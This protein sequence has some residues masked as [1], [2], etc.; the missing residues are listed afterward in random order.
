MTGP[1]PRAGGG[2]DWR[3]DG[4]CVAKAVLDPDELHTLRREADRLWAQPVLF[5]QR[6]AVPISP[7][8]NDRLDPV[9][10]LSPPFRALA[11]DPRLLALA[12]A[13][14]GGEPQ[15]FKDKFI[16][17]PPGADGYLAHQDGAYWQQV[18]PS[19]DAFVTIVCFLDDSTAEAGAIECAPGQHSTL[20]TTPGQ[21]A[22]VDESVLT[23]P[24][25]AIELKA[26]DLLLIHSLTP[27]RSG[28]NR[29]GAMRRAL[30]FTYVV[31]PRP[32]LYDRYRD[33]VRSRQS[34]PSEN[35]ED[36][37]AAP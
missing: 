28:P 13:M 31:D 29:S 6:G 2:P 33:W 16:A 5:E 30:L 24:F 35:R 14:L 18:G 10:D 1:A 25:E 20:L 12:T 26:G 23:A 22:D 34:A 19:P 8:R 3:R 7:R 15:L 27:H 37:G 36:R 4:W 21:I 11:E 9:I 17:K 32:G